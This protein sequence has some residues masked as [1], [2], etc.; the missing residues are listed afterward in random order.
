[1]NAA[2]SKVVLMP[3]KWETHSAPYMG[4]RPQ[5]IINKQIVKDCDVLVGVFWTRVG[6]N[7][8]VAISGTAEEIEQ[9]V[10]LKKP[11]MLYF[12]QTPIEPDKI[13]LSQFTIL[14]TFKEKMRLEGLTESYS[15]IPDFRQKFSRQLGINI[16]N[17]INTAIA[18]KT[19]QT[20]TKSAT[21]K[22]KITEKTTITPATISRVEIKKETLSDEKVNDYLIKAVQS[23]S[24]RS[25]WARIAAVGSYLHTYTPV[26]YRDFSYPKL[27]AFLI[28]RK[29]F[30]FKSEKGH[31][32]LRIVPK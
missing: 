11:V 1:M 30:E 24:S 27:Q 12:S 5:A 23:V 6:T 18:D 14:K 26:D 15:G 8:G 29:L 32:I 3:V 21:A 10:A 2:V 9:F 31:P 16:S 20:K 4:D 28:S 13:D 19:K 22:A 17:L 7:T 25:G